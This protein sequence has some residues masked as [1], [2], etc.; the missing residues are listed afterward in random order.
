[1]IDCVSDSRP[2]VLWL[3]LCRHFVFFL[4]VCVCLSVYDCDVKGTG[5]STPLGEAQ[6]K[7]LQPLGTLDVFCKHF[8]FSGLS[9]Y[10]R[11]GV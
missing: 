10:E 6:S 11:V 7:E 4:F 2:W 9:V 5:T 3:F 1:M 8:A